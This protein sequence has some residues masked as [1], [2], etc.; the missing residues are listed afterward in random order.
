MELTGR[1][2]IPLVLLLM[3]LLLAAGLRFYQLEAQSFWHDEGNSARLAER[4]VALILEGAAGDIHPPLYYL[5][6]HFWRSLVGPGEFALRAL[7]AIGGLGLVALTYALGLRL[8]RRPAGRLEPQAVLIALAAALL[9]AINPFQIYYSQEARSYIWVAF[10][11]AA[12]V[13]TGF[14]VL[15]LGVMGRSAFRWSLA[16][17][18]SITAGLYIHYIF[19][20]VLLPINLVA[21]G[22]IVSIDREGAAGAHRLKFLGRWLLLHLA[23]GL[24][25]LPWLPVGLR[26]LLT[27]PSASGEL[28]LGTA[29]LDTLRLLSLGP[30]IQTADSTAALMGFGLILLVGLV[31]RTA[32][33]RL[34]AFLLLLF[35]LLIPLA[36]I[37]A[38]RLY[39]DAFQKFLLVLSPA[40]CL[41]L[42]RGLVL[43]FS[44][45]PP[46]AK[47]ARPILLL[48]LALALG[49]VL[50]FSY[51]SLENL[52][53]DPVFARA[54][55]R[56]IANYIES[57]ARPGDAVILNAPNQWEVFTYYYSRVD[58]TF[59]LPRSR[60][61]NEAELTA[62]LEQI[63]AEHDRIFA[64]FWGEAES[65]PE[66]MVERWLDVHAYKATD[67]WWG[68]GVRLVTF[69]VPSAPATEIK[70]PL[71]AF[72]GQE[73]VLHGYTILSRQLAPADIIQITLFWETLSP[74]SERY[75]VFL[76]L[77]N[78]QGLLVA[79]RDSEPGGGLALTTTWEPGQ[80]QIDNHGI[81]IPTESEPGNYQLL[82][83]LYP[84]G[85]PSTRLPVTLS[86]EGVGDSLTLDPIRVIRP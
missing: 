38:F 39:K 7:S 43:G 50:S 36:L 80:T 25:Y 51:E 19:P 53:F 20:L 40:F 61:V 47:S 77:L 34:K 48:P 1:S 30:T 68:G 84:L 64:V 45:R 22:Q 33:F 75:K 56:G 62:E 37:L 18:L 12:A 9:A 16:Y 82:L 11:T 79:Q 13:Y 27:W 72:F 21:L 41:L 55:Y 35:W 8:F 6:L 49:L 31:P 10:L 70:V 81:L 73:I 3:I 57:N 44:F 65:D 54:D 60:P 29:L 74:I 26:Q 83:G 46:H 59:P 76:H 14:R 24:L 15:E 66:R 2:K 86:G 17:V 85:N 4:S 28:A 78:G 5:A 69:A 58:Q 71:E 52:Y 42:A 23:A 32:A 63:A 67:A